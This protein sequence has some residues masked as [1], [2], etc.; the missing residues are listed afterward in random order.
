VAEPGVG[1]WSLLGRVLRRRPPFAER[2]HP[3]PADLATGHERAEA[4]L[5]AW[6]RHVGPGRLVLGGHGEEVRGG[7][8][9]ALRDIWV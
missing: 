7:Y 1:A 9:T 6:R 4:F 5:R 2:P 8:E 3:V